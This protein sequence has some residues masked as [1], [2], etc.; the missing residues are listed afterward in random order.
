MMDDELIYNIMTIVNTFIYN[1]GIRAI[2]NKDLLLV[3]QVDDWSGRVSK[4]YTF[5][6]IESNLVR[7]DLI[8]DD[9][10]ICNNVLTLVIKT[11]G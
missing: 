4:K 9:Y 7:F 2:S 10:S 8:L 6:G 1:K 3:L 11:N 5:D